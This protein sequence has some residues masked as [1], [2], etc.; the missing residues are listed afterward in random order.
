MAKLVGKPSHDAHPT[1]KG[2]AAAHEPDADDRPD[3]WMAGAV[4]HPGSLTRLAKKAGESPMGFARKHY[5]D[6][7]KVGQKARFAVNAQKRRA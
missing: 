6:M 3:R 2:H 1:R 7:G 4:K 5:H